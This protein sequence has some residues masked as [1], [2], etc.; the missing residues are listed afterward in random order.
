MR[1]SINWTVEDAKANISEARAVLRAEAVATIREQA[2]AGESRKFDQFRNARVLVRSLMTLG[3]K[4]GV[5]DET[6]RDSLR[7]LFIMALEEEC[8]LMQGSTMQKLAIAEGI[9][10]SDEATEIARKY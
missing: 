3:Y 9:Y 8:P 7:V 2:E 4:A 5:I 1:N 10:K 6:Q